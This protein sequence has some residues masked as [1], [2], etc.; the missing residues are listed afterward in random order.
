MTTATIKKSIKPVTFK[1]TVTASKINENG[2]F[3]GLEITDV[4]AT[5]NKGTYRA[6]APAQ[7]GGAIYLKADTLENLEILDSAT[8]KATAKV[9]LF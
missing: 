2:T 6:V 3:S 1:L 9:K 4:V 5:N 8:A 7:A